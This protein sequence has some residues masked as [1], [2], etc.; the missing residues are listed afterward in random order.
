MEC[1]DYQRL[2]A[3]ARDHGPLRNFN[4]HA[5]ITGPCGDTMEFWLTSHPNPE[6]GRRRAHRKGHGIAVPWVDS[7]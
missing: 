7:Y 3:T 4:V 5:R 6:F 1:S 2:S